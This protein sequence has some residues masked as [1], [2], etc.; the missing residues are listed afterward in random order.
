[1]NNLYINSEMAN[2]LAEQDIWNPLNDIDI[3]KLKEEIDD[4]KLECFNNFYDKKKLKQCKHKLSNRQDSIIKLMFKKSS[5]N[6]LTCDGFAEMSRNNYIISRTVFFEDGS[7]YDWSQFDYSDILIFYQESTI[8]SGQIREI[9]RN[10]PWR[11]IW[12]ISK[13]RDNPL[14]RNFCEYTKDQLSLCSYSMMYDNVHEHPECPSEEIIDDDDCL[15]GWFVAQRRKSE[16]EKKHKTS[17]DVL[18]NPR[19][20]N[21]K[22]IFIMADNKER[23]GDIFDLNDPNSRAIIQQ[24]EHVIQTKEKVQ[25][26]E[27]MDIKMDL[28]QKKNEMFKSKGRK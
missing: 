11:S 16:Q 17:T 28:Q 23:A 19:I 27:F 24:R 1:M 18:T 6:H 4:V 22:E 2:V 14:D 5:L 7:P 10:D 25:D 9:C 15:D 20:K 8:T 3:D 21:A 26:F 12:N 13:K